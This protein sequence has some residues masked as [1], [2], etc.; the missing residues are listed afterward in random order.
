[1]IGSEHVL[2]FGELYLLLEFG[3]IGDFVERKECIFGE[4]AGVA[5]GFVAFE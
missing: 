3:N 5:D 4:S 2:N 1:M